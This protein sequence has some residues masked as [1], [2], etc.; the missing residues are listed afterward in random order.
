MSAGFTPSPGRR[1]ARFHCRIRFATNNTLKEA[2]TMAKRR[3]VR[4][5]QKA[6]AKAHRMKNPGT[7]SRYA[8]KRLHLL[9]NGGWGFNY[10]DPKPWK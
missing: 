9:K 6:Q 5:A 4:R 8:R 2:R 7:T 3:T 10:P 1:E